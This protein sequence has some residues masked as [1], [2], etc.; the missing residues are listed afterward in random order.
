VTTKSAGPIAIATFA[1][2]INLALR[3]PKC[4]VWL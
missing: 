4:Y 2:I 1:T 3:T